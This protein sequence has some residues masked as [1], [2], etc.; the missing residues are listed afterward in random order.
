MIIIAAVILIACIVYIC[1][2]IGRMNR[3]GR[4]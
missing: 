2:D 3:A 1:W 4:G